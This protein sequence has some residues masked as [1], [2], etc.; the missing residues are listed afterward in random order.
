VRT[1]LLFLSLETWKVR[2][3]GV[4]CQSGQGGIGVGAFPSCVD[5]V[6]QLQKDV[7]G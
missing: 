6:G 7:G 1:W 5:G 3:R 2:R 4:G